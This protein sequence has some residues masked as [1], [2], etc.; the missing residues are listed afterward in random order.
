[1]NVPPASDPRWGDLVS[2]KATP[3]FD[4]LAVRILIGTITRKVTKDQSAA[5]L[6]KCTSELREFFAQNA[7]LPPVQNDLKKIFG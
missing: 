2:G 5:N 4:F 3:D 7:D 6:E 1:M